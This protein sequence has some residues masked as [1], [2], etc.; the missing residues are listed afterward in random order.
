MKLYVAIVLL[1]AVK[2]RANGSA[3][4]RA[5]E[6]GDHVID[7][8]LTAVREPT[9]L[10]SEANKRCVAV[11]SNSFFGKN[12]SVAKTTFGGTITNIDNAADSCIKD[13]IHVTGISAKNGC[14][15]Q[16]CSVVCSGVGA[17]C[18]AAAG[19][20]CS[21]C[22]KACELIPGTCPPICAIFSG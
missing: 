15:K 5:L 12:V 22:A 7:V 14:N 2:A 4:M 20:W 1:I 13:V 8:N 6:V 11:F 9:N 3:G 19:W 10:E 18:R 16:C 17:A 21:P